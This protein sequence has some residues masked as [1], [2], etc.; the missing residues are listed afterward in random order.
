MDIEQWMVVKVNEQLKKPLS[1]DINS[2]AQSKRVYAE[3]EY[4]M[5]KIPMEFLNHWGLYVGKENELEIIASPDLDIENRVEE[6]L[7]YINLRSIVLCH[8]FGMEFEP[9]RSVFLL[10]TLTNNYI[11]LDD[12]IDNMS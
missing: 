6:Q 2:Q 1:L 9:I 5:S 8:K 3:R 7:F 4:V 11:R 10:S 12:F